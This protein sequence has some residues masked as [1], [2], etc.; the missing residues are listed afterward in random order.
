[1][2]CVCVC[3]CVCVELK[4]VIILQNGAVQFAGSVEYVTKLKKSLQLLGEIWCHIR[5]TKSLL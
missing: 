4:G 5:D 3:V 2:A 1:M